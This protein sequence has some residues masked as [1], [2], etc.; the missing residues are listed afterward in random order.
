[1]SGDADVPEQKR[2][3]CRFN[4]RKLAILRALYE[5]RHGLTAREIAE[6]TGLSVNSVRCA[7]YRWARFRRKYVRRGRRYV[8]W[9]VWVRTW[10]LTDYGRDILLRLEARHRQGLPLK[11]RD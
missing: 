7:L 10:T 6:Y 9:G 5:A 2:V 8:A 1:M 4:E 11:L 3:R